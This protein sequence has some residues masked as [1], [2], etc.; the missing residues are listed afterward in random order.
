M[1]E[2]VITWKENVS[3]DWN[4]IWLSMLLT[5]FA[6]YCCVWLCIFYEICVYGLPIALKLL[7]CFFGISLCQCLAF[8]GKDRLGWQPWSDINQAG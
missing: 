1:Y 4:C 7:I 6:V 2:S 3:K 8:L 5:G